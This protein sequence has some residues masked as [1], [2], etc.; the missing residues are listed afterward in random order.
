MM[1]VF[2]DD[3]CH[4]YKKPKMH[5]DCDVDRGLWITQNIDCVNKVIKRVDIGTNHIDDLESI[6]WGLVFDQSNGLSQKAR[7]IL[8]IFRNRR[9]T[10]DLYKSKYIL[11]NLRDDIIQASGTERDDLV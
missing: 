3:D 1:P 9:D 2:S 4:Y 11:E 10:D 7:D 8:E 6:L 5:C